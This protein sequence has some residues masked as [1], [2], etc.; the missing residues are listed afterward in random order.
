MIFLALLL[1]ILKQRQYL[2]TSTRSSGIAWLIQLRVGF[3]S[4]HSCR[5]KLVYSPNTPAFDSLVRKVNESFQDAKQIQDIAD[6]W[7]EISPRIT[8]ALE[9]IS[10]TISNAKDTFENCT[11]IMSSLEAAEERVNE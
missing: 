1:A 3:L 5:G 10:E 9:Q 8:A 4:S 6:Q 7:L 11:Q 2:D